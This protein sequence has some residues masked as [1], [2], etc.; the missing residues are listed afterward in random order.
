MKLLPQ[1]RLSRAPRHE[2]VHRVGA[3][4]VL[5]IDAL[6]ATF[7]RASAVIA[8]GEEPLVR[9]AVA[10][11]AVE[12]LHELELGVADLGGRRLGDRPI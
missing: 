6:V 8:T 11:V 2:L 3:R 9:S 4:V 7:A 12:A 5:E 10:H 1:E